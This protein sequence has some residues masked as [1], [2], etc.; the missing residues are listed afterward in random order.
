MGDLG[1]YRLLA[2]YFLAGFTFPEEADRYLS[3]LGVADLSAV[4]DNSASVFSGVLTWGDA[5][6]EQQPTSG[7]GRFVWEDVTVRFR[8]V[9]PRDGA[10]FVNTAVHAMPTQPLAGLLDQF[11]PVD[12]T[13]TA[14]TEYPGVRFRLELMLD[15][16]YFELGDD[17]K[18]GRLDSDHR[19]V[20]DAANND[21]MRIVLPRVV[22]AYEQTDDFQS[23][24][25]LR[26]ESWG[27]SGFDAPTGLLAGELVRME[28]PI[29][30]H[31]SGRLGFGLGE[32]VVDFDPNST[33]PEV[34]RFFGTDEAFEGIYVQSAQLY[35]ADEGKDLAVNAGIK[36]LLISFDGEVSFDANVDLIGPE[37]TLTAT[38]KVID[39]G[40]DVAVSPGRKGPP[41]STLVTGGKIRATTAA[42]GW[43]E[44]VGGV[45]PVTVSLRAG[46]DELYDSDTGQVAF[47][48]LAPGEHTLFLQ[49]QDS[50][51]AA[52]QQSYDED[53]E[54]TLLGTPAAD[55][56]PA[57]APADHAV[58]P[59]ELPTVTTADALGD[60]TH[61]IT[62]AGNAGGTVERFRVSGPGTPTVTAAGSTVLVTDGEFRI[63][64]PEGTTALPLAA[65]WAPLTSAPQEFRLLFELG[66][67]LERESPRINE[68]YLADTV[69]DSAYEASQAPGQTLR[70]TAALRSWLGQLA[71]AGSLPNVRVDAH[72]SFESPDQAEEDLK[73]SERRLEIA[74]AAIGS[75]ANVTHRA[76]HGQTVAAALKLRARPE[77]RVVVVATSTTQP[78]AGASLSVSRERRPAPSV[79][80]PREPSPP[81]KPEQKKPPGVFRRVGIRV[82]VIRN[83]PVLVELTGQ[84]DFETALESSLRNPAV[85]PPLPTGGALE[86]KPSSAAVAGANPNPKDGVVDFRL[87]VVHDPATH[88]WT[89]TLAIGAHPDDINGLLQLTNQRGASVTPSNRLKDMLGSVLILAPII[90]STAAALDPNTADGYVVL[91]GTVVGAAALGAAGFIKT[92][93]ITL[94][95]GELR[96]RQY[97]PPGDPAQFTDAG[98]VFDYGVA[99]G[100]DISELGIESSRAL[101]VR[102]RALGFNLNFPS[103]QYQP[104][105]DTSK[106]YEL[107]L[108]DPGLFKLPSPIDNVLKIL[109]ARIAKVNPLTVE[110]DLGMKVDL[111]VV[112]VDRFKVKLP[113]E[114]PGVPTILPSGVKLD[115]AKVLLGSGYVN[116]IDPP[117]APPGQSDP[118]FGG[119]EGSFDVTLIPLKLRIAARLGIRPVSRDGRNATAVFLGLVIDL[120]TPIPL[121]QSGIGIYGFSGLFAMHFKRIES[122]PDPN[123]AVGPAMLWLRAADGDPT[124]L[125]NKGVRLWDAELDRWSFGVGISLGTIE[126]GFLFNLRGMFVLELPGPRILVFVKIL[127]IQPLPD[128]KPG[129]DL[130]V[131]ILGVIDLDF[132]RRSFTIGVIVDLAIE[133][134]ISVVVPVELFTK[135][136]DLT[137]WHLFV[138]TFSAPSSAL[139][140][141]I[142]RGFGYVMIAGHD[143]AGWPGYGTTRTLPGIAMAAGIGA[144]IVLGDESI[145]LYLKV[146]ARADAGVSFSPRLF[147]VG[148]IQL[149]GELR[150]FIVSVGA[151]GRL[152][153]EGPDPTRISGEVC[154]HVDFFFFSVEGC[155][156]VEIG[157]SPTPP[158]PP[159]LIRNV[160]LQ[161]HA[162]V[163]TAGQGGDRPIDASLGDALPL[164]DTTGRTPPV[165]P[166]DTVPVIQFQTA[167]TVTTATTFTQELKTPPGLRTGG[168]VPLGGSRRVTYALTALRLTGGPAPAPGLPPA[169]WRPDP[170]VR[171]ESGRTNIDL[172]L[173][174]NVPLMGA[175]AMERSADLDAVIDGTWGTVCTP[176][177]PP[178]PVLWTFCGQPL[179]PSGHGWTLTGHAWPD[180]PGMT[181]ATSVDVTLRIEEPDRAEAVLLL[182]GLLGHT[183]AGRIEPAR[184]IGP[185]GPS[186]EGDPGRPDEP[187]CVLLTDQV[188]D[189]DPNPTSTAAPF[190]L[191][192]SDANGIPV[193]ALRLSGVGQNRG[194]DTGR[195]TELQLAQAVTEV[196]LTMVTFAQPATAAAFDAAG[197]LID[198]TRMSGQQRTP[199]ALRLA[200]TGI[201]RVV[202]DSPQDE[203]VLVQV[204]SRTDAGT[205]PPPP[206]T[207]PGS[208]SECMRA[209]QLP[210]QIVPGGKG[211]IELTPELR[212]LAHSRPDER[213][214]D[215][216][217]GSLKSARLYL[218]VSK[219]FLG[220]D[221]VTVE[222]LDDTGTV[223]R[224]DPLGALS[225]VLVGGTTGGL[226]GRWT[227][228]TGPWQAEV[229]PVAELLDAPDFAGLVRLWVTVEPDAATVRLRL[230]VRGS[231]RAPEHPAVVLAVVEILS[232][233]E[234]SRAATEE[235]VRDGRIDTLA[236]YLNGTSKVPLL[237]PGQ[238]YDLEIA[239]R[240]TTQ[241]GEATPIAHPPQTETFRFRTDSAP[242][243][244]LDPYV[245]ATSPRHEERFVLADEA[246][247]IVFNDL[248]VVQL[249]AAYDRQL[250]AVLRAADGTSAPEHQVL[251]L[252]EIPAVHT[253]PLM[254]SLDAEAKA[255]RYPCLGPYHLEGHG[256]FPL[257]EPLRPSMAYTLDIEAVPT[258]QP[259][260]GKP[261]VPLFRRQFST[262]RFTSLTALVDEMKARPLQHAALTGPLSGL[263][264]GGQTALVA[265]IEIE[266]ALTGAGLAVPGAP[267]RGDRTVLWRPVT[268]GR[269]VPHALLLDASEPLWRFRDAPR[270][271]AVPVPPGSSAPA[272]PSF[273]RIVPG[274]EPSLELQ[275]VGAGPVKGFVRSTSGTRTIVFLDDT[276]WPTTGATVTIDAVRPASSLY[277]TPE[278]RVNV[279]TIAL[280]GNAPWEDDDA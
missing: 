118:G 276:A 98:I 202:V 148:R 125:I 53:I 187:L 238:T 273:K 72:A 160:W 161:S 173:M 258:P 225:P 220:T 50:A 204:C 279:A 243:E 81:P 58:R 5:P 133:E 192:V 57:G 269:H 172:A 15:E 129:A 131:G 96:L 208:R 107:D 141:N 20:R 167:P 40:K 1:L 155:V 29:A 34:L 150:L 194:L 260:A 66:K 262:S 49:V 234:I 163:I 183:A 188:R 153:V 36:D 56:V 245:L 180:P 241:D 256:R 179:G 100:V 3:E 97:I 83:T 71:G 267:A 39:Q 7:R 226:P 121:G 270:E 237:A 149:E 59:G 191:T 224:S 18:P 200:G 206:P 22:L 76:T 152:D 212:K 189:G 162:P 145:G 52:E 88:A 232:G 272:D 278:Q 116:I 112:T 229:A 43:I 19:I 14:P 92:E 174:S 249:Y 235:A 139:V 85:Q 261:V 248:Q 223:R 41:P 244:R 157:P 11:L 62:H 277:E 185:N 165:V 55:M 25:K 280:A 268:E 101:K 253:S 87:T 164:T 132:A 120:P 137:N 154:G 61:A 275:S 60:G 73:L 176:V 63:D 54:L 166:I 67:P 170:A 195:R 181:R 127:I 134:I 230:R 68:K 203:T 233:D 199:E 169:T 21:P 201:V 108:S 255:G 184:V 214:V 263:P 257:P 12:Q 126:G 135:L 136:D 182:D 30:A 210:E 186:G 158:P 16:L 138:G 26:L 114:P 45:P 211:D 124:Q 144:S 156:G 48:A 215:L 264:S 106:G 130:T 178:S 89:E 69:D 198:R 95:G 77:D 8:L 227:D 196:T 205:G 140:L 93:K 2:P 13:P 146:S 231:A 111:G 82:K 46:N 236:G 80:A 247:N 74:L 147:L 122:D 117:S 109:G 218:A 228:P 31:R 259:P 250:R 171:P 246:V 274:Q 151:T 38:L 221:A 17:W 44:V 123:D 271:E 239:Y 104:I 142:V 265:D 103:A 115:I 79:P 94:Y 251:A 209:L 119:F 266:E 78:A 217:T 216:V 102:Y 65:S 240:P 113:V 4:H 190:R 219:T 110:L 70:G 28:P 37:S 159:Q 32:V 27:G 168:W 177:A 143:I 10:G 64:V 213:W 105:F 51:P 252:T 254:D 86:L 222:Q 175:R 33:P 9:V 23:P 42:T 35:W 6:K 99:F 90:G 47:T 193:P 207:G 75:L 84:L 128:L 242:P 91:G 197:R 24:P